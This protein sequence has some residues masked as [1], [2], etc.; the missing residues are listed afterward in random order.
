MNPLPALLV[1]EDGRSFFGRSFGA[2]GEAFGEL[3]F[4]TGMSG[5]QETLTDP[6]YRGQVVLATAP[7]IGNTGWNDE[8]DESARIQVAG[9]V[10]RDPAPR[11]S[12]WRSRRSLDAEL[13]N[14]GIVGICDIDTRA[15]TRHIRSLGAMRV[16]ISTR[17]LNPDRL[18]A[19]VLEQPVMA[20]ADLCGE[21]STPEARIVPAVGE[22]R[23][24][25]AAV[26]LGIKGMTPAQMAGRG[27]EVHV[28]PASNG[29][30]DPATAD[31]P[32]TVLRQV[33]AAGI[34]YFG[35]CFGNQLFGR[36]LGFG[37]YK[38]KF[39]HRGINQP[40]LDRTTGKVEITSQNHGFAV[41]APLDRVVDTEFGQASVSHTGLNDDVVEGLELRRDGKLV[42]F[43]VQYH[44]EAAAGPHDANHLFDRFADLMRSRD[45]R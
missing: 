37:T 27:M 21:V 13:A 39:G 45:A 1:L 29:P 2:E 41:D 28:L 22:R 4:S 16:G 5:Y 33:L 10:V 43:S 18:R 35:I 36:A 26:D 8:D 15:L 7:H 38:L 25:V 9:Y 30:G 3:V 17:E 14:Q 40:V 24:T 11:P 32:V 20:G 12:N 42:A 23:F 31:G 19:K 44:P 34:P 6:S